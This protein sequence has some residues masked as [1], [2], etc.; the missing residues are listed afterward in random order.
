MPILIQNIQGQIYDIV[1]GN[2]RYLSPIVGQIQQEDYVN[3]NGFTAYLQNLTRAEDT[4]ALT[5]PML[6]GLANQYNITVVTL[7]IDY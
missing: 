6:F 7:E 4:M 2:V 1:T 5:K 3:L